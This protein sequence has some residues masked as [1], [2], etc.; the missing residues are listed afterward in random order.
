[1]TR[2]ITK[3]RPLWVKDLVLCEKSFNSIQ[4]MLSISLIE[5]KSRNKSL[6]EYH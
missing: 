4:V 5:A 2:T 6:I 1:M 3:Y